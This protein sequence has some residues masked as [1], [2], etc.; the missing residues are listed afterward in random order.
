MNTISFLHKR[1]LVIFAM[2]SAVLF[3]NCAAATNKGLKKI[4]ASECVG[5]EQSV[6]KPIL[7]ATWREF[8]P[9][10]KV[11]SLRKMANVDAEVFL[12]SI[13]TEDF[14]LRN[15][16]EKAWKQFPLPLL[17]DAKGNCLARLPEHFPTDQPRELSLSLGNWQNNI[18]GQIVVNVHN[19]AA[20]GDYRLPALF[21]DAN[22][23]KYV[24]RKHTDEHQIEETQCPI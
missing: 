9:Y 15:P 24:A 19:P 22:K 21:W 17:L 13:F 16:T 5:F 11:C 6:F 4:D 14:Y 2:I 3:A 12:I 20:G 8:L 23:R 18:P 7:S 1:F 10:T